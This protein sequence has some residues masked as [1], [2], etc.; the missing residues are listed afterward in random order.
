[1]IPKKKIYLHMYMLCMNYIAFVLHNLKT[2]GY[3]YAIA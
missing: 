1:M 3:L 2:L